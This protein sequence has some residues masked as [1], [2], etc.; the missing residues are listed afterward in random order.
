MHHG[1]QE[2]RRDTHDGGK[3]P[4]SW[5]TLDR[6]FAVI[7]LLDRSVH[8]H[9]T[10]LVSQCVTRFHIKFSSQCVTTFY[11]TFTSQYVTT[12]YITF[13]S[14][15]V[16]TFYITFVFCTLLYIVIIFFSFVPVIMAFTFQ[17]KMSR[18]CRERQHWP[19]DPLQGKK[20]LQSHYHQRVLIAVIVHIHLLKKEKH[21]WVFNAVFRH[22]N[23]FCV[24]CCKYSIYYLLVC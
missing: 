7:V 8:S 10:L 1:E 16:N 18:S 4:N 9:A 23:I 20:S 21:L 22:T 3:F 14:Q 13:A 12:F 24:S 5:R 15:S 2:V 19:E 17:M 6:F 11:I